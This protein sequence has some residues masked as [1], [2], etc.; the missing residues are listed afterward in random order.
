MHLLNNNSKQTKQNYE[1]HKQPKNEI[2]EIHY[3]KSMKKLINRFLS[4]F[5]EEVGKWGDGKI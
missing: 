5:E 2:R 1:S 3:T 4:L